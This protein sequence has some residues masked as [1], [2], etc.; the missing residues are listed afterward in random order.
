M[1]H[2]RIGME[3]GKIPFLV[4]L[5]VPSI[6]QPGWRTAARPSTNVEQDGLDKKRA[7]K[8][9]RLAGAEERSRTGLCDRR[10]TS[11]PIAYAERKKGRCRRTDSR[12][13]RTLRRFLSKTCR[14][15]KTR[16]VYVS[17]GEVIFDRISSRLSG[18]LRT[19]RTK[20]IRPD[21]IRPSS[22]G[23][24]LR[25]ASTS[26]RQTFLEARS[27]VSAPARTAPVRQAQRTEVNPS[28]LRPWLENS[29]D[30]A[31]ST[32]TSPRPGF[33]SES[34]FPGSGLL[35]PVFVR[36]RVH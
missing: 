12:I 32:T 16:Q 19:T 21:S 35:S 1:V 24:P 18:P 13:R 9:R 33:C 5:D 26:I 27:P 11:F 34:G 36:R 14:V 23:A 28:P 10:P 6:N 25:D 17:H 2:G 4:L 22:S 20:Q 29:I 7:R 15:F 3:S 8:N 30:R 31:V